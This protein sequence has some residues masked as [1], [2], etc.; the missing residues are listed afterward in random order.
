MAVNQPLVIGC[1]TRAEPARRRRRAACCDATQAVA[2]KR[3]ARR[4]RVNPH[5]RGRVLIYVPRS[6]YYNMEIRNDERE[7]RPTSF[8]R[9]P[10]GPRNRSA[11]RSALVF[12][13]S[14]SWKVEVDTIPDDVSLSRPAILPGATDSRHGFWNGGS[15]AHSGRRYRFWRSPARGFTWRARPARLPE[16][17][18]KSRRYHV[19]SGSQPSPS[20]R[21]RELIRAQ[22]GSRG[23]RAAAVGGSGRPPS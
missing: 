11:R 4:T 20:E 15:S 21:V 22:P 13:T 6:F 8:G 3:R 10:N 2:A 9:W 14:D 18:A 5:E 23:Q 19:D 17:A 16:P 12:R 7:P 1:R